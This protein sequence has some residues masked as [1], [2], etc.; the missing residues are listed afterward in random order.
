MTRIEPGAAVVVINEP[1][2]LRARTTLD[3]CI[4]MSREALLKF[5]Y[6]MSSAI[7]IPYC[8]WVYLQE[9]G[10]FSRIPVTVG[11]FL[12]CLGN[13]VLY[14][15]TTISFRFRWSWRQALFTGLSFVILGLG[16]AGVLSMVLFA[17]ACE[18]VAYV[19]TRRGLTR[20]WFNPNVGVAL[21]IA[22]AFVV[23][24][25]LNDMYFRGTHVRMWHPDY[26]KRNIFYRINPA[27][28]RGPMVPV[29]RSNRPRLLF[30]GDS[31][32]FGFSVRYEESFPFV[33]KDILRARGIDVEVVN[34]ATIGQ[35][36]GEI[37]HQLP[38]FL[39]YRPD[40]VFL[41]TGIHYL[42]ADQDYQRILKEGASRDTRWRPILVIPPMLVELVV[43]SIASSPLFGRRGPPSGDSVAAHKTELQSF[44]THLRAMVRQISD[45]RAHLYLADY[46]TPGADRRVQE[47]IR[48]VGQ[49][50][51]TDYIPLF[52][53]IGQKITG[54]L[55]DRIHPDREGH[56][57]IA[58]E[59][60][61][62]VAD[63]LGRRP[64]DSRGRVRVGPPSSQ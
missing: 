59:I 5:G 26:N 62:V 13:S 18:A 12:L 31:S 60:A 23:F 11:I 37:R 40:L 30:L 50:T 14:F 44:T 64:T 24:P 51:G 43:F 6:F 21:V 9:F 39:A 45:S 3:W 4:R 22:L 36:D 10:S 54:H 48:H 58:E 33:V 16:F 35:S 17:Y 28:F 8:A 19:R 57:L 27:G 46:P 53:L 38:Y 1:A 42:R 52:D 63:A 2:P 55:H 32:P 61:K 47:E 7:V 15:S 29:E 41:M 34:A 49:E 25:L 56:R 20:P